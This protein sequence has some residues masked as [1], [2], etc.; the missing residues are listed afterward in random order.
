MAEESPKQ[1]SGGMAYEVILAPASS[2]AAPRPA[3]PPKERP[4]SQEFIT[5]KLKD[6]EDRRLAAEA[7][8]LALIAKDKERAQEAVKRVEE[9]N[10]SFSKNVEKRLSAK[11]EAADERKDQHYKELQDRLKEHEKRSE[12]VRLNKMNQSST[13][14]PETSQECS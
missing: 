8:K 11:F 12:K 2:D 13:E 5:Q 10:N 1:K 3:S 4:L 14:E 9:L 6:A 7:A